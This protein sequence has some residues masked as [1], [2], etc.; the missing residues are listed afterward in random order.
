MRGQFLIG[1]NEMPGKG[2]VYADKSAIVLEWLLRE[3]INRENFSL[4]EI[5]KDCPVRIGLVQRVLKVLV[6]HGIVVAEGI[7]TSKKFA[8][9]KSNLLLENWVREYSILKKCKLW[10]Y[11]F[12]FQSKEEMISMLKKKKLDRKV[13]WALHSAAEGH[14]CKNTN[15]QTTELYLLE[16]SV[17]EKVEKALQLK[18]QET[19]YEVLL[20]EPYY[21]SLL[22]L[23]KET[24]KEIKMSSVLLTFLD[25]YHFPLRGQ[26]QAEF[27]A[28]RKGMGYDRT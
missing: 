1:S 22:Q 19:G 23:G 5:V 16:P 28:E 7:R 18:P 3:G 27:L 20:I 11:R 2:N 12:P 17:R 15:L 24:Y 6:L 25:L 10:T 8:F 26:E 13:A 14:R 4:R 21:K 9:I